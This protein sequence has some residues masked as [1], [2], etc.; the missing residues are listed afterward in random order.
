MNVVGVYQFPQNSCVCFVCGF[1]C[2]V[3]QKD[4]KVVVSHPTHSTCPNS[5]QAFEVPV[6]KCESLPQEFF[7]DQ[8]G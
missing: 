5:H 7:S 1:H 3:E 8:I 6:T 2:W 4:G